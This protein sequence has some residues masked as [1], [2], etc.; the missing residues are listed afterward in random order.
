MFAVLGSNS[1]DS[2]Q[3][4]DDGPDAWDQPSFA[5]LLKTPVVRSDVRSCRPRGLLNQVRCSSPE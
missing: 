3:N 2:E 1:S 5:D 4:A